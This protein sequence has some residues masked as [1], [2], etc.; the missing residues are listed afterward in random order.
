MK[1]L[2][3]KGDI[4]NI[5][6]FYEIFW[7]SCRILDFTLWIESTVVEFSKDQI[8]R[9]F[10]RSVMRILWVYLSFGILHI[11]VSIHEGN[12]LPLPNRVPNPLDWTRFRNVL[13]W[14]SLDLVE[15]ECSFHSLMK[16]KDDFSRFL[17]TQPLIN[18]D[19]LT[20]QPKMHSVLKV[21]ISAHFFVWNRNRLALIGWEHIPIRFILP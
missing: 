1:I 19:M 9:I 12:T 13:I 6:A 8:D 20:F 10:P 16:S 15:T 18:F 4:R 11:P 5:F 17:M 3:C 14:P 7:L 21:P 2:S